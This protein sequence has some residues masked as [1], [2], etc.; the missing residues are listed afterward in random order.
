MLTSKNSSLRLSPPH[1]IY[2]SKHIDSHRRLLNPIGEKG[3]N[4]KDF[5]R[6]PSRARNLTTLRARPSRVNLAPKR[7]PNLEKVYYNQQRSGNSGHK[8]KNSLLK[9][10]LSKD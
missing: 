6:Q 7:L 5:G 8:E 9:Q 1:D 3:D 10:Y 2:S 4:L